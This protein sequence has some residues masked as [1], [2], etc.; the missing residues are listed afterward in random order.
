[1]GGLRLS[2]I[3]VCLAGCQLSGRLRKPSPSILGEGRTEAITARQEADAQISLGRAAEQR[4]DFEQA[5]LAYRSALKRDKSRADAYH[6]LAVVHDKQGKFRESAEFY[7]RALAASPRDPDLFCDMGYS[8][9]LQRRWAEAERRLKQ[10]IALDREHARAHNNLGLVLA[11]DGRSEEAVTEF[12]KSGCDAAQAHENIA[13]ALTTER[14]W[15]EARK[16][17]Q[18][19]LKSRP[20]SKTPRDRLQ[21]LD[22]LVAKVDGAKP[23]GPTPEIALAASAST[24]DAAPSGPSQESSPSAPAT[25]YRA[26]SWKSYGPGAVPAPGPAKGREPHP[27]VE[28]EVPPGG[29]EGDFQGSS[30]DSP[31]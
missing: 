14:R 2:V 23:S 9:Y 1:M 3:F 6:R 21:Q 24:H 17:Y 5:I 12:R 20:D 10:A 15:V 11:R 22:T 30:K 8:L 18:L 28:L 26:N 27:V 19:A 31:K 4:G 13:F 25:F 29:A 16:Q 7:R